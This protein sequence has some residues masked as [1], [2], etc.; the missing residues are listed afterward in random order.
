MIS[1]E[2]LRR[3]IYSSMHHFFCLP[4]CLRAGARYLLYDRWWS[5]WL[6][7]YRSYCT[8]YDCSY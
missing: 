2:L 8:S 1:W 4:A 7:A 6:R 3:C 5:D